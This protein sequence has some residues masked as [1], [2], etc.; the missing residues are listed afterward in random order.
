MKLRPGH[1]FSEHHWMPGL[2]CEQYTKCRVQGH[3]WAGDPDEALS[4]SSGSDRSFQRKGGWTSFRR[5]VPAPG[6]S[7]GL[8]NT[9]ERNQTERWRQ[10]VPPSARARPRRAPRSVLGGSNPKPSTS[11]RVCLEGEGFGV[12]STGVAHLG[13]RHW[14]SSS[15]PA[16]TSR[17]D[18]LRVGC[19]LGCVPCGSSHAVSWEPWAQDG[20]PGAAHEGR[21]SG[22]RRTSAE[23]FFCDWF[24]K[25]GFHRRVTL[26]N[27][28]L[29][30]KM[31]ENHEGHPVFPGRC[32][33]LREEPS[34][35]GPQ[36]ERWCLGQHLPVPRGCI[37]NDGFLKPGSQLRQTHTGGLG[38]SSPVLVLS[39][40]CQLETLKES[41]RGKRKPREYALQCS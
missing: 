29:L 6:A 5:G 17:L 13:G 41:P 21:A 19:T 37:P 16:Q 40:C 8:V 4:A 1:A 32:T 15:F 23:R 33:R 31:F 10:D 9:F 2:A 7:W 3:P 11:Q 36:R 35:P 27:G 22:L 12:W 30:L 24:Y 26:T 39:P 14:T 28:A 25:V 18:G 38:P 20:C 34:L